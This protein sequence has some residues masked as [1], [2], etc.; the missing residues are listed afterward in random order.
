MTVTT[1]G[2]TDTDDLFAL[3]GIFNGGK[4]NHTPML[5]F[6]ET[7]DDVEVLILHNAKDVLLLPGDTPMMVQWRG[8]W[9]SDF[10]QFT[11]ADA[12]AAYIAKM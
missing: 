2:R 1:A 3:S 6:I 9:S 7:P 5:A 8:Q 12:I 11:A 10:F 4:L